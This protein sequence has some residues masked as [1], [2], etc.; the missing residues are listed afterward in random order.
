MTLAEF[1][2]LVLPALEDELKAVV[3][4]AQI[5]ED[6]TLLDMLGYHMGWNQ[7]G[8]GEKAQ[9]KRIRPLLLLLTNL[10]NEGDWR[11]A[12]PAAAAV[13]LVHNFS[14]IHDDIE[15]HSELRRGRPTLWVRH[16]VPL[17]LNAGDSMFS[18]AYLALGRLSLDVDARLAA[19]CYS[20]LSQTCLALTKGQHLDLSFEQKDQVS[21]AAYLQMIEGKTAALLSCATQL[22]AAL[23]QADTET[24]D[25]YRQLGF[26][27]GIAFQVHDD[28]L[29]IWGNPKI[30]GKSAASDLIARK[31]TLPILFGLQVDKEFAQIWRE[32]EITAQTAPALGDL[33]ASEG[34]L[35]YTQERAQHYTRLALS[36]FDSLPH[37]N[38][39]STA[40]ESLIQQLLNR[41]D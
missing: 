29:G 5:A 18:L 28:Y 41:T 25:A 20:V 1:T 40:L 14:L 38:Q 6:D 7:V 27:L 32:E 11:L 13:E 9:G 34:A 16:S 33:L 12:L 26:N 35:D 36:T 3:A 19:Q 37:K 15:D 8:A 24:I 4:D 17:A 21:I 30:T 31:K 22:G 23:A 2:S 10:A 39:A